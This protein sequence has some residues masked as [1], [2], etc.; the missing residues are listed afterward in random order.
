[1][2]LPVSQV[3]GA[4]GRVAVSK[5][6]AQWVAECLRAWQHLCS[7]LCHI[8]ARP[9]TPRGYH[10]NDTA[11][12]PPAHSSRR[13]CPPPSPPTNTAAALL[14]PAA[15]SWTKCCCDLPTCALSTLLWNPAVQLLATRPV[16]P[17]PLPSP[18]RGVK[19]GRKGKKKRRQSHRRPRRPPSSPSSPSSQLA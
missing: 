14:S 3:F 9:W 18:R 19:G 10:S 8:L 11:F 12:Q 2:R 5:R 6:H 16:T 17:P 4:T 1:M 7:C 13:P 15:R